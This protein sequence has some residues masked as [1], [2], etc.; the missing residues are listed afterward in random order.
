MKQC[1]ECAPKEK[2]FSCANHPHNFVVVKNGLYYHDIEGIVF[3]K[4]GE[5][6]CKIKRSDF[7][8][9]WPVK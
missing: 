9:Q 7:G 1:D 8:F 3:W 2:P 6:K 4:D 5:P